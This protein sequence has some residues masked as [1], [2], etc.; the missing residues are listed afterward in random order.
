MFDKVNVIVHV[1]V[2]VDKSGDT[3]DRVKPDSHATAGKPKQCVSLADFPDME[4]E[5]AAA[6]KANSGKQ[7]KLT[8]ESRIGVF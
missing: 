1:H 3:L 4:S 2:H 8:D 7:Q 6:L 5:I